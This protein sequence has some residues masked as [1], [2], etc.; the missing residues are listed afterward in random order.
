MASGQFFDADDGEGSI[1]AEGGLASREAWG[2]DTQS[3][4]G[5]RPLLI[6]AYT[7]QC[8]VFCWADPGGLCISAETKGL[9]QA[10]NRRRSD[11][12]LDS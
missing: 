11:H 2:F 7:S 4:A 6:V 12:N 10:M 3:H 9:R 5:T 8:E 1:C